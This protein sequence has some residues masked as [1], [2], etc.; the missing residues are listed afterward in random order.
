MHLDV[1]EVPIGN[2]LAHWRK[3]VVDVGV[4]A[5]TA[6]DDANTKETTEYI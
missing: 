5:T 2:I 6:I 3:D 4:E 1:A